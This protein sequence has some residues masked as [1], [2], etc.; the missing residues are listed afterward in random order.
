LIVSAR[1]EDFADLLGLCELLGSGNFG[2]DNL[3]GLGYVVHTK[4]YQIP[5]AI[6]PLNKTAAAPS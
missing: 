4:K 2:E 1:K 6:N 5:N 3:G